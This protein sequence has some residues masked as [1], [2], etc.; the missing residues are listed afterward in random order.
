MKIVSENPFSGKTYF[1]TISSRALAG[2]LGLP[3]PTESAAAAAPVNPWMSAPGAV[4]ERQSQ[5]YGIGGG[6]NSVPKV[7]GEYGS[8]SSS[9]S[10]QKQQ[11]Q[12]CR[13]MVDGI[14]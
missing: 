7:G 1:Y 14:W 2:D 3:K 8:S 13:Q 4:E 12:G 11:Q 10:F 5:A 9:S 6:Y